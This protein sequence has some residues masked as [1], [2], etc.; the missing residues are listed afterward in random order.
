MCIRDS[1]SISNSGSP[2]SFPDKDI[3]KRFT[4]SE[5]SKKNLGIGLSIVHRICQLYTFKITYTYASEHQFKI[6]FKK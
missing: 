4:R 5:N 1:F 3:F 6:I 2:L